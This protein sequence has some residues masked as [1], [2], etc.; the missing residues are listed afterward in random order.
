[1]KL[2]TTKENTIYFKCVSCEGSYFTASLEHKQ[3]TIT[4]P[5]P[6]KTILY[7]I[8][9]QC[10]Q[11]HKVS[12]RPFQTTNE[13]YEVNQRKS[14]RLKKLASDKLVLKNKQSR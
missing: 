14:E 13:K 6:K 4:P 12:I 10:Q 11:I 8:C 2:H 5:T 9:D 7:L 3:G 1:M